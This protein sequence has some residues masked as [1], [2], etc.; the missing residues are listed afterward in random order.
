M[1]QET[2]RN[3]SN[4]VA[5]TIWIV[6]TILYLFVTQYFLL[7]P[8]NI[9]S[10]LFWEIC[11]IYCIIS[12]E[13][14]WLFSNKMNSAK[15]RMPTASK[16]FIT[17]CCILFLVALIGFIIGLPFFFNAKKYANLIEVEDGN[18]MTD[19]PN[20]ET[21]P[22]IVVDQK[23][24]QK[25]GDRQLSKVKNSSFYDVDDEYNLINLDGNYVRVSPLNYGSFK[26]AKDSQSIP[27][28][29]QVEATNL[30]E[31]QKA[32]LV[33][34]E[35]P[36]IYSPSAIFDKKLKRALHFKYP[37]Y[38]FG[39]KSFFEKDDDNNSYWITPIVTPTIGL[40]SG[41]LEKSVVILN[42]STGDAQI[43]GNDEIP[44]WVDHAHSV[45][46]MFKLVYYHY[47]YQNGYWNT[48]RFGSKKDVKYTSDSY[49]ES[50]QENEDSEYTPYEG[51]N[52]VIGKDGQIYAYTGITS[53]N[54][55]ESNDGFVLL[56]A[57][58]AKAKFY[59]CQG[60]EESTVQDAAENGKISNF[61]YSATFPTIG[62]IGDDMAYIM[63]LKDNAGLVQYYAISQ[64]Q[65]FA[66]I[67]Q[68]K[69]LQQAVDVYLGR[70]PSGS[71]DTANIELDESE[72]K[73]TSEIS[74]KV[75]TV[76]QA[77]KEGNTYFF[78]VLEGDTNIYVS[79]I[80]ISNKQPILLKE[81]AGVTM[82]YHESNEDGVEIV[83]EIEIK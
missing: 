24:A 69:T 35:S 34:L 5:G 36:M 50:K 75:A 43:Y 44:L 59:S 82:K 66:K 32:S 58:T 31:A 7:V 21:D 2:V 52:W 79:P 1:K 62:H 39:E 80:T 18:E 30:G 9:H 49:R 6:F 27:A 47:V 60:A 23:S 72:A 37:T 19:I 14:F 40:F 26:K 77:S 15:G 55:A 22:I 83:T 64:V 67:S 61:H 56:N 16:L 57:R 53:A 20:I 11:L 78:I 63:I 46:Y 13:I 65:N 81:G 17:A 4:I 10:L 70:Q 45:D 3:K 73:I 42:A 68:E 71:L 12:F 8:I 25:I 76:K 38:I 33:P 28:Y 51:Y 29:I 48:T 54:S 41:K 74:G